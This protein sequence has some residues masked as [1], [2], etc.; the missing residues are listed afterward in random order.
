MTRPGF[1][2]HGPAFSTRPHDQTVRLLDRERMNTICEQ[3]AFCDLG[4]SGSIVQFFRKKTKSSAAVR[5][6][7]DDVVHYTDYTV[8]N[9][10]D[11][12]TNEL[13]GLTRK[14]AGNSN[15]GTGLLLAGSSGLQQAKANQRAWH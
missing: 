10:T 12:Q 6:D 9:T 14:L 7:F 5:R 2:I 4:K 3:D 1:P 8:C 15:G 11:M 13:R